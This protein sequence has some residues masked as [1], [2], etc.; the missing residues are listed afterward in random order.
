MSTRTHSKWIKAFLSLYFIAAW[1][2]VAGMEILGWSLF[3]L[4][5]T[6]LWRDRGPARLNYRDMGEFL[7][8]RTM[9]ALLLITII[10]VFANGTPRTDELYSIGSQRWMFILVALTFSLTLHPPSLKGYAVFLLCASLIAAYAV[11]QSFTGLDL[12]RPNEPLHNLPV[13]GPVQLWRSAGLFDNP[14]HYA[15]IAGMYVCLPLAVFFLFPKTHFMIRV[16]S[17]AAFFL[18]DASL[19]TTYVRGA[20]IALALAFVGMSFLVSRRLGLGV[21]ATGIAAFAGLFSFVSQ[22]R[23]RILQIFDLPNPSTADRLFLW[24]LNWE[25]FKDHPIFG[26][27]Y[28]QN[29]ERAA[30]Y[31]ARLG[32][33]DAFVSHAHNTYLHFLSG[34]GLLGFTAYLFFIGFFLLMTV[35]LYNRIPPLLYWARALALAAFGAQIVLHVGGLT[36]SNFK[37]VVTNHNF[38]VVLALVASISYLERSGNLTSAYWKP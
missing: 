3:L 28:Q 14:M 16:L 21:I 9:V 31:A 35:R 23:A 27:G 38:M 15:Y 20:W 8:W 25:M 30:E 17:L 12:I 36:E 10:G 11:T 13:T 18:I 4:T 24:R 37:T 1:S 19:V 5:T 32:H 34:S 33:P 2:T 29:E 26:I 6:Y 7:P 22:F